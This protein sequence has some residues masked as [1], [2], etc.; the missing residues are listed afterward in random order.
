M[1]DKILEVFK[2]YSKSVD[3]E[4]NVYDCLI[5][6]DWI[7]IANEICLITEDKINEIILKER[8]EFVSDLRRI[9]ESI[10]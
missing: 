7:R 9:R 1:D 5:Q 10:K 2:R 3:T 4:F 6:E 8:E